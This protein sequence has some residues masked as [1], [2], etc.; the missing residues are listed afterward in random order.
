MNKIFKP[1]NRHLLIRKKEKPDMPASDKIDILMPD[2]YKTKKSG[3][4]TVKLVSVA[5][6]CKLDFTNMA[7]TIVVQSAMIETI[8]VDDET[9]HIVLE[10]Y[11][12]A[13]YKIDHGAERATTR[14][15]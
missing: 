1:L 3:Y 13:G 7:K 6:D 2:G 11:V 4:E 10:N 9:Y 12:V 14:Q 8:E 5:P 15:K